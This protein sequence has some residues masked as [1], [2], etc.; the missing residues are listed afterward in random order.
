MDYLTTHLQSTTK[1]KSCTDKYDDEDTDYYKLEDEL[2]S[3][4]DRFDKDHLEDIL[5]DDT[6]CAANYEKEKFMKTNKKTSPTLL[7]RIKSRLKEEQV[8]ASHSSIL[9]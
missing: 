7:L 6:V 2:Q 1:N 4:F 3:A 5:G 9:L 8:D